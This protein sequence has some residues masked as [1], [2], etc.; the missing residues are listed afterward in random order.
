MKAVSSMNGVTRVGITALADLFGAHAAGSF[1]TPATLHTY[2]RLSPE[3]RGQT[4]GPKNGTE[5]PV[6]GTRHRILSGFD[7]TDILEYGGLLQPR[8]IDP[9]TQVLL[10]FIP[11]FPIYP[12]ETAWMRQPKTDIPGLIL[13]SRSQGGRV[14]FLPADI[15][16]QFGRY[17]L[18]DH[19]NLLANII[20]WTMKDNIP[21]TID[22]KGLVDCHLYSQTGR[23]I[24]HIVNLTSAGTWRQPV[25]ELIPV[26][27]F[28]VSIKLHEDVSGKNL[29]L[30]VSKLN[31]QTTVK[32][33]WCRFEIQSIL[34]H[35]VAVIN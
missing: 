15:D 35:E 24:L 6:N 7:E 28:T 29:K 3:L 9:G 30:L 21:L 4:D 17:N 5:P 18:P 20:R 32:E 12:P 23:M 25:D 19:G 11:E 1:G 33:G 10:T 2:L 27:P 26:G 8:R 31:V 13:N 14:V 22:G 34:D 16:R